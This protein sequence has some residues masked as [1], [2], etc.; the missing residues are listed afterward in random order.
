MSANAPV[1]R[2]GL[3]YIRKDPSWD[4][5]GWTSVPN[6]VLRDS[7]LSWEARGA[8]AWMA[9]HR[10]T[11]SLRSED[12][13]EAGP[14]GRNHAREMLRELEERG[15]L[16]RHK[17]RNPDTG[18]H[19][20]TIY[21]L[22]PVQ[23]PE[24]ERTWVESSAKAA[25]ALTEKLEK[26]QVSPAT[27]R[28]GAGRSVAERSGTEREGASRARCLD[29]L[30]DHLLTEGEEHTAALA[31]AE[32]ASPRVDGPLLIEFP[33]EITASADPDEVQAAFT[34]AQPRAARRATTRWNNTARSVDADR[35]VRAFAA[36]RTV[37]KRTRDQL[38][39]EV[40]GLLAEG[41]AE[42]FISQGMVE[43][44]AKGI[45]PSGLANFVAAVANR[46][47]DGGHPRKAA[48]TT[49]RFAEQVQDHRDMFN[50]DG[51]FRDDFSSDN[52]VI[53]QGDVVRQ[54]PPSACG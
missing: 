27:E 33:D 18:R 36:N 46:V 54:L 30:E 51:S 40:T 11:F 1:R 10:T 50:P 44:L 43:C 23:V 35:L 37:P 15:W 12:L 39:V 52:R 4:E 14:K 7:S 13:A 28:P 34:G 38:G 17:E 24:A 25:P 53:V 9:S 3:I 20:L 19:E 2:P 45:P 8:F 5:H 26:S 32:A 21:N 16:T 48:T 31:R 49:V 29:P 22:H 6:A 47:P 41:I 42:E